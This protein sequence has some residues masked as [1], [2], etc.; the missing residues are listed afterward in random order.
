M[1]ERRRTYI[2]DMDPING[3]NVIRVI[4]AGAER[5]EEGSP[6][7]PAGARDPP[8]RPLSRRSRYVTG[9]SASALRWTF[10]SRGLQRA[11]GSRA[12]AGRS[13]RGGNVL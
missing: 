4:G 13:Q 2:I 6:P 7:P 3:I 10:A 11:P 1:Y 12:G 9:G 5:R 8:P